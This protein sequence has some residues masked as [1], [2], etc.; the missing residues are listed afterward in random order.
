MNFPQKNKEPTLGFR[1]IKGLDIAYLTLIYFIFGICISMPLDR[2]FGK[3]DPVEADKQLVSVLLL[4]IVAHVAMLGVIIYIVRN[5][6][7]KIPSPFEGIQGLQHLK[8]KELGNAAVFVFFLMFYQKH[9]IDKMN[10]VY[11]RIYP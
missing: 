11:K 8:L 5:I 3:F 6:V 2:F 1:F 9:L 10:Y 4:E 7:E